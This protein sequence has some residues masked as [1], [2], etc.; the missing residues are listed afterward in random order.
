MDGNEAVDRLPSI[1]GLPA[2]IAMI[3]G[4]EI[5]T[6]AD[7]LVATLGRSRA[8]VRA[9]LVHLGFSVGFRPRDR[10]RSPSRTLPRI[11]DT[12]TQ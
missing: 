11:I 9:G 1:I 5:G 10:A 3:L 2:D 7:T 4:A 12:L 8:A 6:C